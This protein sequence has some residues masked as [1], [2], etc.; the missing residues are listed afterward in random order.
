MNKVKIILVLFIPFF[1]GC[2]KDD[3]L[4][5]LNRDYWGSISVLKNREMWNPQIIGLTVPTWPKVYSIEMATYDSHNI[6]RY[7]LSIFGIPNDSLGVFKITEENAHDTKNGSISALYITIIEDGDVL[8]DVFLLDKSANNYI[9]IT[10]IDSNEVKGTFKISLKR[11]ITINT[12][13]L[14]KADTIHFTE[15]KFHTRIIEAK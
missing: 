8:G 12:K 11:D 5:P 2:N 7:S 15:G 10:E 13:Y 4:P 14:E 6:Q 9:E 1:F 3:D